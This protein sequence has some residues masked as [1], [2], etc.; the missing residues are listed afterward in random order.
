MGKADAI[1]INKNNIYNSLKFAWSCNIGKVSNALTKIWNSD[2]A[3][4]DYNISKKLCLYNNFIIDSAKT[5]LLPKKPKMYKKHLKHYRI[6]NT[7]TFSNLQKI[8]KLKLGKLNQKN[9][10]THIAIVLWIGYV[11]K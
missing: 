8:K 10:V 2:T 3:W 9:F 5:L 1:E 11:N 6:E 7:L 4:E